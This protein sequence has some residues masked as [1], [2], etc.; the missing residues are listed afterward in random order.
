[1]ESEHGDMRVAVV[2][3]ANDF[4]R[5]L[6]RTGGCAQRDV[7]SSAL[8]MDAAVGQETD[9][10]AF[11]LLMRSAISKSSE[12]FG[13]CSE[14]SH[15]RSA[16]SIHSTGQFPGLRESSL[17]RG[18]TDVGD[19]GLLCCRR[20]TEPR[21]RGRRRRGRGRPRARRS[22]AVMRGHRCGEQRVPRSRRED[23]SRDRDPRFVGG[24][25][26]RSRTA[27]AYHKSGDYSRILLF[28]DDIR[29][30]DPI[31]KRDERRL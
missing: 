10:F 31:A 18:L 20:L 9:V 25:G 5:R 17:Y 24:K 29:R 13:S 12:R 30:A 23:E 28:Q 26:D 1:M 7:N 16:Q 27:L 21:R 14:G 11:L 2:D 19:E 15:A 3:Q 22:R 8:E 6:A 4:D